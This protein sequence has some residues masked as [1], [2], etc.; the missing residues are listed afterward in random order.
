ML[1]LWLVACG[2]RSDADCV[3][4]YDKCN[5]GC[6]LQCGTAREAE[7]VETCD[8]GCFD[9][10]QPATDDDCV[11]RDGECTFLIEIGTD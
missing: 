10:G 8:L 7:S 2:P 5:S 9:S 3:V 4:Y 6:E 1:W 11:V